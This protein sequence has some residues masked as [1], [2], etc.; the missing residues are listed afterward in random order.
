M[1]KGPQSGQIVKEFK[2]FVF[3]NLV[4]IGEKEEYQKSQTYNVLGI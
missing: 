3:K 2:K 4:S 1:G